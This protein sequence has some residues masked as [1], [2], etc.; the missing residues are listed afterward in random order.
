MADTAWGSQSSRKRQCL[1]DFP[2]LS[3]CSSAAS[4]TPQNG[5]T[6]LII[7]S[8][9]STRHLEK[10]SPFAIEKATN[11]LAGSPVQ[12]VTKLRSGSL[13]VQTKN[14]LQAQNLQRASRF[15]DIPISISLHN[16][17]NSSK[18]ILRCSSLSGC[19]DTEILEDLTNQ[20]VTHVRRII[21]TREG[22][23]VPT[24]T[25]VLTF[26]S[27]LPPKSIKVGYEHVIISQYIPN[28]L[29]CN[30]CQKFG[31]HFSRCNLRTDQICP[32]CGQSGHTSNQQ[33]PCQNKA[34]CA[35]C[36]GSH[37]AYD[38]KCPRWTLEKAILHSKYT[39]NISFPEAR[40]RHEQTS[41]SQNPFTFAH[42]VAGKPKTSEIGIQCEIISSPSLKVIVQPQVH[43]PPVLQQTQT[44]VSDAAISAQLDET[45]MAVHTLVNI[46]NSPDAQSMDCQLHPVSVGVVLPPSTPFTYKTSNQMSKQPP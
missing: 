8:T 38:I 46:L 17:L 34:K 40:K 10:L 31:H 25:L 5:T 35:N 21:V 18:G 22:K 41:S 36:H 9:D 11:C 16:T 1:E 44:S 2:A 27:S 20:N 43:S 19:P 4:L 30:K 33:T 24:N 6:F 26:N 32:H 15:I 45:D 12:N 39:L 3:S 29:R 42:I 14:L 7:E 28:P 37:P 13:L 23:K